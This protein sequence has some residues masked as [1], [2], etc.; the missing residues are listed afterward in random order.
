MTQW[1]PS[2]FTRKTRSFASLMLL[3]MLSFFLPESFY[4]NLYSSNRKRV[5]TPGFIAICIVVVVL[6]LV[7]LYTL[8]NPR[9]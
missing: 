5:F 8:F 1:E 6:E 7:V 3:G 9:R 2:G 4:L